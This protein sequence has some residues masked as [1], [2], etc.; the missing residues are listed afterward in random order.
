MKQTALTECIAEIDEKIAKCEES[1]VSQEAY[2][3]D[4]T[5]WQNLKFGLN[6]AREILISKL[7]QERTDMIDGHF[8][9]QRTGFEFEGTNEKWSENYFTN[10]FTQEVKQ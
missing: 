8:D 9:G 6:V 10:S 7:P 4:W 5:R 3:D 1:S 2:S